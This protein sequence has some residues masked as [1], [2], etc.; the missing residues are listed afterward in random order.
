[1]IFQRG[2]KQATKRQ[3]PPYMRRT[4]YVLRD[5][6]PLP[7]GAWLDEMQKQ[8]FSPDSCKSADTHDNFAN[9][10]AYLQR[11]GA[12]GACMTAGG[13]GRTLKIDNVRTTGVSLLCLPEPTFE[14]RA[15]L[16]GQFESL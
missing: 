1:M 15:A 16:Q 6:L 14:C 13:K 5:S 2:K 4:R 9:G 11:N 10:L 8:D 12:R 7:V 3:P